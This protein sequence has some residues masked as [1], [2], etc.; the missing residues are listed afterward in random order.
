MKAQ[1]RAKG[2]AK[3]KKVQQVAPI[4]PLLLVSCLRDIADEYEAGGTD[5]VSAYLEVAHRGRPDL[6]QLW[7]AAAVFV[8]SAHAL[9]HTDDHPSS[10]ESKPRQRA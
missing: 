6:N 3:R 10:R 1:Q 8:A 4:D 7:I 9:E 2:S 5:A